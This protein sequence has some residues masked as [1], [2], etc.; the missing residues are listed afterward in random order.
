[1][2]NIC[3][4]LK[5]WYFLNSSQNRVVKEEERNTG[6]CKAFY[7]MRKHEKH[8]REFISRK[9]VCCNAVHKLKSFG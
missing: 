4:K 3:K 5:S 7:I 1:M 2:I 8:V 6:S 9:M